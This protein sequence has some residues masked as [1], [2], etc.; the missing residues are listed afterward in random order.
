MPLVAKLTVARRFVAK[1]S[2]L[3]FR[4]RLPEGSPFLFLWVLDVFI[5]EVSLVRFALHQID[6]FVDFVQLGA[7]CG[8]V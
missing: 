8:S 2:V 4:E 1:F 7:F 3:S 6:F 5:A